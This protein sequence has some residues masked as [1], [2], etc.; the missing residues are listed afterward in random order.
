[1]PIESRYPLIVGVNTVRTRVVLAADDV[2]LRVR[3][4]MEVPVQVAG[5]RRTSTP[6]FSRL[7]LILQLAGGCAFPLLLRPNGG[8]LR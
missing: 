8:W 6:G 1:V 2:F 4:V 7:D 5:E 3:V